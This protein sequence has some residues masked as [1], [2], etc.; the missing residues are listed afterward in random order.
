[1]IVYKNNMNKLIFN[2]GMLLLCGQK[3]ILFGK[4]I[5]DLHLTLQGSWQ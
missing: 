5:K 4:E 3:H 2:M 1:M